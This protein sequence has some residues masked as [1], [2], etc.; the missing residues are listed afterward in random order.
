MKPSEIINIITSIE[1]NFPVDTWVVKG[2]HVW[3][4]LRIELKSKIF[5]AYHLPV[6]RNV[7]KN[8]G[9]LKIK[10]LLFLCKN[11]AKYGWNYLLDYSHNDKVN[12]R[13][14]AV[15][16]SYSLHRSLLN[17]KWYDR[18]CDPLISAMEEL[19]KKCFLFEVEEGSPDYDYRIPR[20]KPSV[21]IKGYIDYVKIKQFFLRGKSQSKEVNL[22]GF[23]EFIGYLKEKQIKIKYPQI[24]NL[25]FRVSVIL[26]LAEYFIKA[27]GILKPQVAFVADYY[28]TIE[29]FAY[30]LACRKMEIP[31]IDIQHGAGCE[32]YSVAYARW[33]KV[34]KEGYELLPT[35]FWC[36]GKREAEVIRQW[37]SNVSDFH[38]PFV[39]GNPWLDLWNN[40]SGE[41]TKSYNEKIAKL[42]NRINKPYFI[43]FTLDLFFGIPDWFAKV[44]QLS[45]DEFYWWIRIHPAQVS[46]R[47]RIEDELKKYNLTNI[48]LDYATSLP[49]PA[50]LQH[51]DIHVTGVSSSSIEALYFGVPTIVT[52]KDAQETYSELIAAGKISQAYTTEDLMKM[53]RSLAV[54]KG[55]NTKDSDT[56]LSDST[57]IG[58]T[59]EFF[60]QINKILNNGGQF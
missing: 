12:R 28:S 23:A 3:P 2:I 51:C 58:K 38:Y 18:C 31:C 15:F 32:D 48:E 53:I 44:I 39:G 35:I 9:F 19:G 42:K 5:E 45:S 60:Q 25:I 29:R 13:C 14:E 8:S 52:H 7:S 54:N 4:L 21:Y 56:E 50:L 34:P 55:K 17:G 40:K 10:K 22:K 33:K 37:N 26:E 11:A 46:Q 57:A 16:L 30:I 27:F 47:K 6:S 43:L 20:F 59:R 41:P 1:D 36:W 24:N 49:L